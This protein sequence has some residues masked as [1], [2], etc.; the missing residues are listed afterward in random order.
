MSTKLIAFGIRT[1]PQ[2]NASSSDGLSL[3]L[4]FA[5]VCGCSADQIFKVGKSKMNIPVLGKVIDERFLNH[6]LRSTHLAGT[7]GALVAIGLRTRRARHRNSG[8]QSGIV[9]E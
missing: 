7:V 3:A 2:V 6:R 5:R 1:Q 8:R 4:T 9:N